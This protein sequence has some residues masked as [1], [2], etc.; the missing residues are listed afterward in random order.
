[1]EKSQILLI[2]SDEKHVTKS[3][4]PL[5]LYQ[6]RC[7]GM[8]KR[9]CRKMVKKELGK[10]EMEKEKRRNRSPIFRRGNVGHVFDAIQCLLSTYQFGLFG[11]HFEYNYRSSISKTIEGDNGELMD[12]NK[13]KS[14]LPSFTKYY[15]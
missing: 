15:R 9:A 8:A 5:P 11:N 7:K 4:C 1:M 10:L 3:I 13:T 14:L 2:E 6:V 12:D